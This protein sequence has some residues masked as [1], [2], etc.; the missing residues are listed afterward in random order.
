MASRSS[1]NTV[2]LR[3]T[4]AGTDGLK[5]LTRIYRPRAWV[6]LKEHAHGSGHF[7]VC[8]LGGGRQTYL[9]DGEPYPL[10]GG[11]VLVIPP[12]SF[13]DMRGEYIE[14]SIFYAVVLQIDKSG[15]PF[16]SLGKPFAR[17][18]KKA[19]LSLKTMSF[20]GSPALSGYMDEA[21]AAYRKRGSDRLAIGRM[22]HSVTGFLLEVIRC[23][24]EHRPHAV[25]AW[26]KRIVSWIDKNIG[27]PVSVGQMARVMGMS[28]SQF[29]HTFKTEM[30]ISPA[31]YVLRRKIDEAKRCLLSSSDTITSIA[32]RFGFSSSQHFSTTF[33]KYT[34]ISPS[35][36][37]RA[38]GTGRT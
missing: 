1:R 2:F 6:S 10:V 25:T 12:G 15:K 37:R 17:A 30:G 23:A 29:K 13:H 18:L 21:I 20:R 38:S 35:S 26:G 16:M 8:Y 24:R 9:I 7:E 14:K 22:C 4:G 34:G 3:P 11:D 31:D 36:Y 32:Y 27:E 19:L 33:K 28:E 5:I